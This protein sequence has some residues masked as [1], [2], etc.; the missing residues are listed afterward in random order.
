MALADQLS[1]IFSILNPKLEYC[2]IIVDDVEPARKILEQINFPKDLI[3]PMYELKECCRDFYYDYLL[4]VTDGRTYGTLPANVYKYTLTR[5]KFVCL[6]LI[7]SA[8]NF[9]LERALRYYKAHAAEF[10]M[11][12]T[13]MSYTECGI[14]SRR[15]TKK[16]FNF[17]RGTQDLYYDFQVAKFAISCVGGA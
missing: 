14:D 2:A 16:L 6:H 17:G 9:L 13:G 8:D 5:D 11:F 7:N 4:C 3:Y 15:F 10:D 12:A 1:G